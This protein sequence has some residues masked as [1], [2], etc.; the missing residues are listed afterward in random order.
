MLAEGTSR[1]A[2]TEQG[3]DGPEDRPDISL[4]NPLREFAFE[5]LR[6]PLESR[7]QRIDYPPTDVA[8]P[9]SELERERVG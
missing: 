5:P 3:V 7:S 6:I 9:R 1:P 4:R 2:V 8:R